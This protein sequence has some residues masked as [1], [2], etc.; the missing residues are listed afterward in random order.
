M[1]TRSALLDAAAREVD[2]H[3]Y[4]SVAMRHVAR[5]ADVTT[6]ALTFHFPTKSDLFAEVAELGLT[7][8]RE[9]ADEV[10]RLPVAP[11]RRI[12]CSSSPCW[13][14]CTTT[15]WPARPYGSHGSSRAPATGRTP[16]SRWA[17]RCCEGP[18]R[19]GSCGRGDARRG[20]G[21]DLAPGGG[22]GDVR[23]RRRPGLRRW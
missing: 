3:G 6:G 9:R 1:L 21:D 17:G 11:L 13:S 10:A 8:M 5:A 4:G 12:S 23:T 22:D 14:C 16:G 20:G 2:A 18:T 15:S 19:R 7:R